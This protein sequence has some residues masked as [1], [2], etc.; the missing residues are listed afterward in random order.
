MGGRGICEM[1]GK[2]GVDGLSRGQWSR[3]LHLRLG[4]TA[5]TPGPLG[6]GDATRGWRLLNCTYHFQDDGNGHCFLHAFRCLPLSLSVCCLPI[7]LFVSLPRYPSFDDQR[8]RELSSATEKPNATR[9]CH[10]R[11]TIRLHYC[12]ALEY[13]AS[14]RHRPNRSIIYV[15]SCK[16][17]LAK[18][19][20]PLSR[21]KATN[22]ALSITSPRMAVPSSC[23]ELCMPPQQ[24]EGSCSVGP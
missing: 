12:L 20:R 21:S 13:I 15:T 16:T 22:S 18:P 14:S 4:L 19:I 2:W 7:C 23:P 10:V 6:P 24:M 11:R 1:E 5:V 9:R 3:T 8:R 17:L